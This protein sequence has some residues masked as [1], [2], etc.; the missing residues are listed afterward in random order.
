MPSFCKKGWERAR[1][2][3]YEFPRLAGSQ[4]G[5]MQPTPS[6]VSSRRLHRCN[7]QSHL[8]LHLF[9]SWSLCA[10]SRR[11]EDTPSLLF[12]LPVAGAP[13]ELGE[14]RGKGGCA[15]R[16]LC[17]MGQRR[18]RRGTRDKGWISCLEEGAESAKKA[19]GFNGTRECLI[20]SSVVRKI[21]LEARKPWLSL[22]PETNSHNYRFFFCLHLLPLYLWRFF[23]FARIM[24]VSWY[25]RDHFRTSIVFVFVAKNRDGKCNR[26][27]REYRLISNW[28]AARVPGEGWRRKSR[29][30]SRG[31]KGMIKKLRG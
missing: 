23:R 21:E 13:C 24:R 18:D 8:E 29:L 27:E 11:V 30:F 10:L 31:L 12:H 4:R 3:F 15:G 14:G 5:E 28:D 7:I 9:S 2:I 6:I 19:R 22:Q 26:R 1:M 20:S 17:A 25:T 16:E